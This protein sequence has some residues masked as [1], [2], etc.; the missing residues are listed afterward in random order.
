MKTLRNHLAVC[1]FIVGGVL[2]VQAQEKY[3]YD[4]GALKSEGKLKDGEKVGK[5]KF[6]DGQG[7]L[8][9]VEEHDKKSPDDYTI[10]KYFPDGTISVQGTFLGGV[11]YNTWVWNYEDGSVKIRQ[12]FVQGPRSVK[13]EAF[14]ENGN[15]KE[16]GI[17]ADNKLFGEWSYYKENGKLA[18]KGSYDINGKKTGIWE[19]YNE[20]GNL[21]LRGNYVDGLAHREIDHYE[22]DG[23]L[24]YTQFIGPEE[25]ELKFFDPL[26][27]KMPSL[28]NKKWPNGN[29]S[30]SIEKDRFYYVIKWFYPEGNLKQKGKYTTDYKPLDVWECYREDGS[31]YSKNEYSGLGYIAKGETFNKDGSL[32][33]M[34]KDGIIEYYYATG[35]LRRKEETALIGGALMKTTYYMKD[36]R[37]ITT[38]N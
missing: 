17:I 25:P 31:L 6:Y 19:T 7:N 37:V 22:D 15:L 4:N 29:T 28:S 24:S 20:N 11:Q 38:T 13:H 32:K 1:L 18:E 8:S 27:V 3:Y 30:L 33:S 9:A 12:E 23:T 21:A 34:T 5:W 26:K 36:G 16:K 35:E 10:V 14:Y 2:L